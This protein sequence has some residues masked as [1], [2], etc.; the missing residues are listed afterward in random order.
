VLV[1]DVALYV[2]FRIFIG[3]EDRMLAARF[4]D[5]YATY[6]AAVGDLIPVPPRI[7]RFAFDIVIHDGRPAV[8]ADIVL[9]GGRLVRH[10][11]A[12]AAQLR[13]RRILGIP[14][15]LQSLAVA[16]TTSDGKVHHGRVRTSAD[17]RRA[18]R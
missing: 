11:R 13:A 2:I 7:Q 15:G 5:A 18:R 8:F 14:D 1:M 16:C 4:G 6:R 17:G 12:D 9:P 10:C 3:D